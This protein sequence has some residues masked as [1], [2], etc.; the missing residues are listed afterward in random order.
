MRRANSKKKQINRSQR[1]NGDQGKSSPSSLLKFVK[2]AAGKVA[3]VF[4]NFLGRRPSD[5]ST[6]VNLASRSRSTSTTTGSYFSSDLSRVSNSSKSTSRLKSSSSYGS[7]STSTTSGGGGV[8]GTQTYS[9]QEIVKATDKF[10]AANKIGEGS[11]GTVYKGRLSDG[12][13]VAVKRGKKNSQDK[14]LTT[15]FRNEILTLSKIEHLNLVRLYGYV[16]HEDEQI[17]LVEY[18]NNGN[19]REHLDNRRGTVLEIGERL[20]VAIDVA[21]AITYLHMYTDRAIIHRDI[22]ASNILLTDKLRAKVADFG[23]ARLAAEDSKDTHI[24]T[25]IKGT[26]GY[27]D[28]EYLRTYTLTEKSD[29]FSFGVLLVELVTGRQPIDQ[30]RSVKE[31]VTIKWVT[32]QPRQ[33][34]VVGNRIE[35]KASVLGWGLMQAMQRLRGG[36]AIMV[37]DPILRR[38][39]A[40]NRAEEEVLK[41]AQKCLATMRQSRPSM[42]E[43]AEVLWRIRKEFREAAA[44]HSSSASAAAAPPFQSAD[45]PRRYPDETRR[46]TFGIEDHGDNPR[47]ISA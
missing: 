27:L 16:E 3:G 25:Q 2:A 11:F 4:T 36:D 44:L 40:S 21:H 19:L 14:R 39:P 34:I 23:F 17:L 32:N 1:E 22:K 18:V 12:S 31:K 29:V 37:M 30:K 46:T 24:S 13:L 45:Y 38:N 47:F 42:K 7:Y 35:I 26:T 33:D 8:F 20:D 43:C 5:R 10:S 41:L 6:A 28:P 9:L 15:E